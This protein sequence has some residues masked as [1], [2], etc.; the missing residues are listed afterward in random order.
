MA[1]EV[2][3]ITA[4]V[5]ALPGISADDYAALTGGQVQT[6]GPTPNGASGAAE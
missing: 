3:A 4:F 5:P 6:G 1:E 2:L